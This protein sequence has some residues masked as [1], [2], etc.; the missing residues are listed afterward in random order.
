MAQRVC[1]VVDA[2][3]RVLLP[4]DAT[5][6]LVPASRFCTAAR[7]FSGGREPWSRSRGHAKANRRGGPAPVRHRSS[8]RK[9]KSATIAAVGNEKMEIGWGL[10]TAPVKIVVGRI[11]GW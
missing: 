11:R 9:R 10:L 5:G 6:A 2:A 1:V 7:R 8:I 3:E 4:D